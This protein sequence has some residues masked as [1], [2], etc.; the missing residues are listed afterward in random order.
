MENLN[1]FLVKYCNENNIEEI[2]LNGATIFTSQL[3][4]DIFKIHNTK[5]NNNKDLKVILENKRSNNE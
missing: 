5:F 4:D 3:K 2:H 1:S